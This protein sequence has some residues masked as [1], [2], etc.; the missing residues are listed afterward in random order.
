VTGE[1]NEQPCTVAIFGSSQNFQ[2]PQPVRLHPDKP[3]FCFAPCVLG[4]FAISRERPLVSRYRIV[5]HA[6]PAVPG[7]YD[8][9]VQQWRNPPTV[10]FGE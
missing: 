1:V 10:T 2:H 4:E 8:P 7:L 6:G 9:L 3:Y 5:T